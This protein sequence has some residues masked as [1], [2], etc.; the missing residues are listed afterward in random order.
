VLVD[1]LFKGVMDKLCNS[2]RAERHSIDLSKT[3]DSGVGRQLKKHEIRPPM[4]G[5]RIGYNVGFEVFY[6][7]RLTPPVSDRV[8]P[9]NM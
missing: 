1:A 4:M 7:H 8:G 2:V 6:L 3:L 9:I 5:R